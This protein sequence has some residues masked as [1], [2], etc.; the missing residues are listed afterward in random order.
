ML[1]RKIA[2]IWSPMGL[3]VTGGRIDVPKVVMPLYGNP[4]A[5]EG[6]PAARS[7]MGIRY[8]WGGIGIYPLHT[9]QQVV[10]AVGYLELSYGTAIIIYINT[11]EGQESSSVVERSAHN[12]L[13]AGSNPAEPTF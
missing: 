3:G 6:Y 11:T 8:N 7:H 12:R 4:R 10:K 1:Q 9:S 13:V 5:S 2:K